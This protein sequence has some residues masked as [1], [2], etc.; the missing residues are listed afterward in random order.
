MDAQ[1]N[2][3]PK[4]KRRRQ[5]APV[6]MVGVPPADALP[7]DSA[8]EVGAGSTKDQ[9]LKEKGRRQSD[10]RGLEQEGGNN[11]LG[12]LHQR[13]PERDTQ[14]LGDPHPEGRDKG[15]PISLEPEPEKEE[16]ACPVEEPHL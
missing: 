5:P 3:G 1:E 8:V 6:P 11:P 12:D 10:P 7:Q 16:T 13:E 2:L 9:H 15:Q 14:S 4:D